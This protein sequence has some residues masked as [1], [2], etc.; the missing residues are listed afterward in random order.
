M[1]VHEK[2]LQFLE[3]AD[4]DA[5]KALVL[6]VRSLALTGL[7]VSAGYVRVSPYDHINPPEPEPESLDA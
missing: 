3:A 1:T 5:H 2:V 7:R 4:G 6:A